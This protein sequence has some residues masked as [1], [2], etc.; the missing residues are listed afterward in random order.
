[1][2]SHGQ[3][4]DPASERAQPEPETGLEEPMWQLGL[5]GDGESAE[6]YPERPGEADC[7]HYIRTGYCGYGPRCRFNHPPD[8]SVISRF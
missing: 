5:G 1:M 4:S 7:T 8:R 2:E 6:S 3:G